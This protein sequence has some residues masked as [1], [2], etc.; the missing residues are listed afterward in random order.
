MTKSIT[1]EEKI[2]FHPE[3]LKYLEKVFPEVV[4]PAEVSEASLRFYNGQRSI[5]QFIRSRV[6][7]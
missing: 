4:F 1:E 6:R 5:M 3:Q 2:Y 7:K